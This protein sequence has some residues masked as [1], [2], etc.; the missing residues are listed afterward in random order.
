MSSVSIEAS[1][2]VAVAAPALRQVAPLDPATFVRH[3]IHT[4]ERDW[5]ETNCYTDVMVE[6]LHGLG[7]EPAALLA[8]TLAIDFEGDQWTF[9]KPPLA[10]LDRLYGMDVQELALWKPLATHLREQVSLGRPVMVELDSFYLPDT[11]GTTYRASHQKSGVAVN[12]I[13]VEGEYLGYFHNQGYY[14]L[15]GEDFREVLGVGGPAHERVLPPYCELIKWRPGFT[16]PR[17]ERLVEESLALLRAH[18]ARLP[19]ANPFPRFRSRFIAD[20]EWLLASDIGVF[21]KY[22]FATLRQYGACFELAATYLRW[23]ESR[24]VDG[25]RATADACAEISRGTKA[26]QFQLARSMARRKA[27]DLAPLEAMA[28][29]WERGMAALR[30]RMR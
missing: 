8:F 13:D 4:E 2:R 23:L 12:A 27:L 28:E 15:E 10:D 25:L 29:H 14:S 30:A 7:F 9:F 5:A 22:S 20:L 6:L 18:T 3:R 17:G 24:G 21:H 11:A 26:F 19:R 16:A 1:P